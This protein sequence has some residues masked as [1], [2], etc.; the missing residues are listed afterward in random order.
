MSALLDTPAAGASVRATSRSS[1]GQYDSTFNVVAKDLAIVRRIVGNHLSWWGVSDEPAERLLFAVNE[2]L[3]NVLEHTKPDNNG[4]RMASL[5]V[6]RVPGG[7]TAVVT[8]RDPRPLTRKT[9]HPLDESGRG[10]TLVRALVDELSVS[11]FD[12]HK[13]VWLFVT[14]PASPPSEHP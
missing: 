4:R 10:L 3:S 8:D 7:A 14:D 1:R 2:L 11:M 6:Q 12:T 13:D 5:L 9:A